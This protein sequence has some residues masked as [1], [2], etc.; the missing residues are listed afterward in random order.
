MDLLEQIKEICKQNNIIPSR[1]KGQNFLIDEG[2]Y[3]QMVE[4]AEL[5]IDDV[6][7]EVGPGLGILTEKLAQKVKKVVAVELD[8]KLSVFLKSKFKNSQK[9]EIVNDGSKGIILAGI[10]FADVWR[11]RTKIFIHCG[12][13]V[14][15]RNSGRNTQFSEG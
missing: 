11:V 7:L 5:N 8:D 9:V 2:V 6:V 14:S 3:E 13:Q 12:F 4:Y 10:L 1:S 15:R